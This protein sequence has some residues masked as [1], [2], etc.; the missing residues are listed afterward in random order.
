[1]DAK[2]QLKVIAAGFKI[3]RADDQPNIRIKCK[4]STSSDWHTLMK[5]ETKAAR[6]RE[7]AKLLAL[8]MVI[9]D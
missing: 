7:M 2:S 4:D 3:I 9:T 1:M 8:Q 6:D 5:F